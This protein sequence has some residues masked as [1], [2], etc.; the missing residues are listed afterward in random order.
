M[1]KITALIIILYIVAVGTLLALTIDYHNDNHT[2]L[3]HRVVAIAA[4][5]ILVTL[6]FAVALQYI[7]MR[8]L[9]EKN[10]VL[11][12]LNNDNIEY[13]RYEKQRRE[14]YEKAI[15]EL[16]KENEQLKSNIQT[17]KYQN[18]KLDEEEKQQIL[19][20]IISVMEDSNE[21]YKLDF[22]LNELASL[23]GTNYKY[24]SQVINESFHKNFSSLL[25]E[26]RV[27]EACRRM[28][29]KE[30]YGQMTIEGIAESVGFGSRSNFVTYFKRVTGMTPSEYQKQASE[31]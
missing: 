24:V 27:Q 11:F 1:K 23:T 17:P 31:V 18:S 16:R 21:I 28:S 25:N 3:T 5:T 19:S 7:G 30:H 6:I 2:E 4:N 15:E 13:R 20:R 26:F 8:K 22:S 14:Q 29:D 10:K 12:Q 9:K